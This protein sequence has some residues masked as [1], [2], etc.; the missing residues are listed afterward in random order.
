MGELILAYI[1][2]RETKDG[3]IS[4]RVQVRMKGYPT[5]TATFNRITDA[6]KWAA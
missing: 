5:Q 2:K 4:F 6:K 1:E 3:T